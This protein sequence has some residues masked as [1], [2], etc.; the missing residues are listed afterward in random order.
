M[1]PWEDATIALVVLMFSLTIIPMIT[2]GTV[3]PVWTSIPMVVG[4]AALVVA[5]ISL[6]L[7]FSV[8]VEAASVA[9]WAIL[10]RRSISES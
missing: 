7:W 2:S 3:V 6:G 5:Y 1:M 4:A 9:L 8:A 10:A